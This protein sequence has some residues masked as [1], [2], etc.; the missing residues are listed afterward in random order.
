[1]KLETNLVKSVY[2]MKPDM[3]SHRYF[4]KVPVIMGLY[5]WSKSKL[6][7]V[8]KLKFVWQSLSVIKCTVCNLSTCKSLIN[9]PERASKIS[10]LSDIWKISDILVY[11]AD[12]LKMWVT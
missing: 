4:P 7:E 12:T 3:R 10:T 9:I 2:F 6:E 11:V 1:M 5:F 8:K